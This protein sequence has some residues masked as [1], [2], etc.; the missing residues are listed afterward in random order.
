MAFFLNLLPSLN[1]INNIKAIGFYMFKCSSKYIN[2]FYFF[3]FSFFFLLASCGGGSGSTGGGNVSTQQGVFIDSPVEGLKFDAGEGVTGTTGADG[4]FRFIQGRSVEFFIGGIRL[5][6]FASSGVVTPL[7]LILESQETLNLSSTEVV[8]R[9][10][11]LQALDLDANP[12]NGITLPESLNLP[13]LPVIDFSLEPDLFSDHSVVKQLVNQVSDMGIERALP[14]EVAAVQRFETYMLS[15]FFQGCY[16]GSIADLA[17]PGQ[18]RIKVF[19]NG[20]IIGKVPVASSN[21]SSEVQF[22]GYLRGDGTFETD[23]DNDS[24]RLIGKVVPLVGQAIGTVEFMDQNG[25]KQGG[26]LS[27]DPAIFPTFDT[28]A[29]DEFVLN[30]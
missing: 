10:R 4:S 24:G 19:E 5:G 21:P 17:R 7:N 26:V 18:L 23:L 27:R 25:R 29:C 9:L 15:N 1:G 14:T 3:L 2:V 12:D 11:L 8:N 16:L 30:N 22:E 13:G 28:S 20:R 6:R